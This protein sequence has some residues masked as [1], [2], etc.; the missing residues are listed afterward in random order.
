MHRA[1]RRRGASGSNAVLGWPQVLPSA[2]PLTQEDRKAVQVLS[3][4][5]RAQ[6]DVKQL[7]VDLEEATA[8]P[9]KWAR[10]LPQFPH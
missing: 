9:A 10:E 6:V 5:F 1:T 4:L 3:T 7:V 8:R 2:G